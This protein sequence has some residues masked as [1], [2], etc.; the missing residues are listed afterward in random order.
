MKK[1]K[2]LIRK[3]GKASFNSMTKYPSILTLHKIAGDGRTLLPELTTIFDKEKPMFST[4]KIDGC[5]VRL[6]FYNGEFM[7]GSRDSFLHYM[8]DVY[9]STDYDIVDTMYKLLPLAGLAERI[10]YNGY[11]DKL[12]VVYGE[13][14]GGTQLPKAKNYG[15]S[16]MGFRV[17]DVCVFSETQMHDEILFQDTTKISSWREGKRD[18]G[19]YYG[20][21]FMSYNFM[22]AFCLEFGFGSAPM[23]PFYMHGTAFDQVLSDMQQAL[24][25]TNV[26]LSD[27]ALK[28]P[29]GIVV[30]TNDRS[31]IF[32]LRF[33]EYE[34]TPKSR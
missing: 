5:N 32:K 12:V 8:D 29:E 4:E 2:E 20:Q 7:I 27:D 18:H 11:H 3:Y 30:R 1:L 6:V 25:H 22:E 9:Y 14:F 33:E 10:H 21:P 34:R 24:P 13:L 16:A 17:F 19:M 31:R 28:R 26:A 15:R 23:V